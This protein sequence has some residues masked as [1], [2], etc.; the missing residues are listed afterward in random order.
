MLR[1]G[2][3]I[4]ATAGLLLFSVGPFGWEVL[5]SI[6]PSSEIA[7]SPVVY[8][9][10]RVTFE[11]YVALFAR[12]DFGGYLVNSAVVSSLATLLC[13][14]AGMLAAYAL[15]K[16]NIPGSPLFLVI[17]LAVALVP[18]IILL[19]PLYEMMR[20]A[21]WINHRGALVLPYAALNLPFATLVLRAFFRQIP[22]DLLEAAR[23]DGFTRVGIL[24]KIIVPLSAPA[25]A[26]TAILVFVFCWNEF[27]FALTFI[28]TDAY[29]TIPVG[30]AGLSGVTSP[31]EIPWGLIS[32]AAV[33][34]TLPLIVLVLIFQ[35]RIVQGLTAGALKG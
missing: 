24:F 20:W 11:H 17:V 12:R 21:D 28:T 23:I 32:A 18:P 26:T 9:P 19:I 2:C 10:S 22:Q 34:G 13:M 6:K 15:A 14:I 35:R 3:F 27:I 16:L 1:K 7:Q 31:Y 33:T 4:L 25:L 5:T 29:K 8:V 30:I